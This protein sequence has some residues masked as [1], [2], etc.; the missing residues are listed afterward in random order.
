VNGLVEEFLLVEELDDL[1]FEVGEV[2]YGFPGG[3]MAADAAQGLF[4]SLPVIG[5]LSVHDVFLDP[6]PCCDRR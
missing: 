4:D 5:Q 6:D 2:V 1:M 3:A